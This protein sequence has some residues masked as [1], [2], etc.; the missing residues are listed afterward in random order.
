M[1]H[2]ALLEQLFQ[3]MK[4][5]GCASF[6]EGKVLV[7]KRECTNPNAETILLFERSEK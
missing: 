6:H 5:K 4:R 1:P 3:A 7:A 2:T